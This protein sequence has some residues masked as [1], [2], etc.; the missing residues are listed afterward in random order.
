LRG[1]PEQA[2]RK[3][4][5]LEY[6]FVRTPNFLS[7]KLLR[8]QTPLTT[9]MTAAKH[10]SNNG[11]VD[12]RI[13]LSKNATHQTASRPHDHY[14][15]QRKSLLYRWR[16]LQ[17]SAKRRGFDVSISFQLFC[18]LVK[19]VCVYCGSSPSRGEFNGIDRVM[20]TLGYSPQNVVASCG[21][22]NMMK[23]TLSLRA[24][25]R[26]GGLSCRRRPAPIMLERSLSDNY[27]T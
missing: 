17:A 22:C 14:T 16:I 1:A 9:T 13:P 11:W 21:P 6:S 4:L 10:I 19:Q 23:S 8:N 15:V 3:F 12:R 2:S 25:M 18:V 26:R 24:F 27:V 5:F 20:C 7:R